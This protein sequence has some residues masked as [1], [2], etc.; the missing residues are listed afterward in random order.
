MSHEAKGGWI[1]DDFPS[2][3]ARLRELKARSGEL[4]VWAECRVCGDRGWVWSA[5]SRG[6]RRCTHCRRAEYCPQPQPR[7]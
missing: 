7:H 1:A 2:I 6:W 4:A 5:S 3:A